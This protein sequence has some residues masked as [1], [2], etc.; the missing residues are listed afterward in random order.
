MRA[1]ELYDGDFIA[2]S[3]H[4]IML[5]NGIYDPVTS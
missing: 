4:P 5:V 1:R 3:Q 2:K